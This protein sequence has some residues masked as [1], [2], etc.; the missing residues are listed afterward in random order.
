M[1]GKQALKVDKTKTGCCTRKEME[2]T[3]TTRR[4]R[5]IASFREI[6]VL[7]LRRLAG[8]KLLVELVE[9]SPDRL[10]FTHFVE[11]FIT[12]RAQCS[13]RYRSKQAAQVHFN[14]PFI[15]GI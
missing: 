14:P 1:T 15:L 11:R 9:L 6:A 5:L 13:S 12:V 8:F 3:G 10:R 4:Q 7:A 2:H